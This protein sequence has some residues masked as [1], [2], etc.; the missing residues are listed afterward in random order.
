M[1]KV[2]EYIEVLLATEKCKHQIHEKDIGVVTPYKMQATKI[3]A[4][5]G[6]NSW[7]NITIGTAAVLQGQ[8][9]Q[10]IIISTVSVGNVSEFAANFRRINVM[11]TRAK[12][13][14]IIIGHGPTLQKNI[15]WKS[16]Y[17][18]CKSNE[19]VISNQLLS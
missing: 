17:E 14:L 18:Y 8:E 15:H 10:I 2:I 16:V 6:M 9:K 1:E 13:L 4:R 7:N 3:R 19:S 5:C 11:L 12:S